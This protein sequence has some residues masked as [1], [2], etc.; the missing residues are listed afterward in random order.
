MLSATFRCAV[1]SWHCLVSSGCAVWIKANV[2]TI[3][4]LCS[5][6]LRVIQNIPLKTTEICL[7]FPHWNNGKESKKE[8]SHQPKL[9]Y[10]QMRLWL[11]PKELLGLLGVGV[12]DWK[13]YFLFKKATKTETSQMLRRHLYQFCF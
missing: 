4:L 12:M 8:T 11:H 3:L 9:R 13:I 2:H 1:D 5:F 10:L 6:I 7:L